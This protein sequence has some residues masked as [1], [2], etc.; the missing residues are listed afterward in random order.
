MNEVDEIKVRVEH[1]KPD[2][3]AE[4]RSWFLERDHDAWDAQIEADLHSG[5]LDAL[6]AEAKAERDS[7]LGRAL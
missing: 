1:L 6:I 7:G 5:K 3:Q 2:Q 4:L